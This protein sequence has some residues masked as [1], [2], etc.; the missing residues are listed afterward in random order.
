M[1]GSL[2]CQRIMP[3]LVQDYEAFTSKQRQMLDAQSRILKARFSREEGGE[4]G[5]G[6][7]AFDRYSTSA[8]NSYATTPLRQDAQSCAR[9]AALTRVVAQV[10]PEQLVMLASSLIEAPVSSAC[11]PSGY[12]FDADASTRGSIA[13]PMAMRQDQVAVATMQ[14]GVLTYTPAAR[15]SLPEHV[16]PTLAP[17]AVAAAAPVPKVEV[18][19]NAPAPQPVSSSEVLQTAVSAL[20]AATAALQMTLTAQNG[21]AAPTA[22]TPNSP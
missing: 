14:D 15:P 7:F 22:K 9:L 10:S 3:S 21:S 17:P 1:V 19:S 4:R 20:Q 13:A 5:D 18:A 6:Q 12:A 16:P 2:Q 11:P 8:A